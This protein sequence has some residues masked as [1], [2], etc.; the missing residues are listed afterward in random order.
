VKLIK[1][2][3]YILFPYR[4]NRSECCLLKYSP[5]LDEELISTLELWLDEVL[6]PE[7]E[8]PCMVDEIVTHGVPV[9]KVL[10]NVAVAKEVD[11]YTVLAP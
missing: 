3:V 10:V 4:E 1:F 8:E 6:A 7:L 11:V 5:V 2:L 9:V